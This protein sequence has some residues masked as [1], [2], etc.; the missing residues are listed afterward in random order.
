MAKALKRKRS[1]ERTVTPNISLRAN[2]YDEGAEAAYL[3]IAFLDEDGDMQTLLIDRAQIRDIKKIDEVLHK[4]NAALPRD[5][6][7]LG[8]LL[9]GLQTAEPKYKRR[10][11]AKVGWQPQKSLLFVR[12]PGVSGDQVGDRALRP[13]M[14]VKDARHRG[15]VKGSFEQWQAKIAP[16][17][18]YSSRFQ[19]TLAAVCAAPLTRLVGLQ[20]FAIVLFGQS[21]LGKSSAVLV[22]CSAQGMGAKEEIPNWDVSPSGFHELAR[23]FNDHMLAVDELGASEL[24]RDEVYRLVRRVTYQYAEGADA[25]RNSKSAFATSRDEADAKGILITTSE[26]SFDELASIYGETRDPGEIARAFNVPAASP[27]A[28]SIFD[29]LPDNIQ[30]DAVSEWLNEQFEAIRD[31]CRKYKGAAF[32]HYMDFITAMPRD[33]LVEDVRASMKEFE[34]AL[35]LKTS[36]RALLHAAKNFGLLYAGG[37]LGIE[38]GL[39]PVTKRRLRMSLIA[40]FR[41]GTELIVTPEALEKAAVEQLSTGMKALRLRP[42]SELVGATDAKGFT[43]PLSTS[44]QRKLVAVDPIMFRSWFS[45]AAHFDA[46]IRRLHAQGGLMLTEGTIL[47]E[48]SISMD[49]VVSFEKLTDRHGKRHNRRWIRFIEPDV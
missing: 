5:K 3:E 29:L 14:W 15:R 28:I 38:A 45:T 19:L 49:C 39:L 48:G 24:P 7:E 18:R 6:E 34:S 23:T 2:I 25:T 30:G 10:L 17:V 43:R 31:N 42:K 27:G 35:E 9:R 20:P 1:N 11:A 8:T 44:D 12:H 13:P 36:F 47:S 40:C 46:L 41:D 33:K 4:R 16:L 22:A 21:S 32:R 37:V 26:K